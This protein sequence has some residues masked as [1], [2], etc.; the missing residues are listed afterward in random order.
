MLEKEKARTEGEVCG[1][2]ATGRV[3]Y[4]E[5]GR[6]GKEQFLELGWGRS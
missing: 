2:E 4:Q 5:R 6:T 1:P 3:V